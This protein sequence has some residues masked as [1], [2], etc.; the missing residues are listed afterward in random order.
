[1][2]AEPWA[3]NAAGRAGLAE[4]RRNRTNLSTLPR[5]NN[6]FEDRGSHQT[7][8][9]SSDREK[10]RTITSATVKKFS[11]W[12]CA[13]EPDYGFGGRALGNQRRRPCRLPHARAD[14]KSVHV[15]PRV[16]TGQAAI[17][18]VKE[19]IAGVE[20]HPRVREDH[21]SQS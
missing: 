7:P 9:A 11:P 15:Q 3:T 17:R 8:F 2:P 13:A 14:E 1:M 21:D 10:T 4:A 5:R 18:D 20:R 16:A 19:T 6:G 12:T